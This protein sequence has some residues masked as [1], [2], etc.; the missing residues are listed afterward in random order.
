MAWNEPQLAKLPEYVLGTMANN[1]IYIKL[2]L[3]LLSTTIA[4]YKMGR[5]NF[6]THG[7]EKW[8]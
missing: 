2:R 8:E 5:G 4:S 7:G 1:K 6:H 3:L